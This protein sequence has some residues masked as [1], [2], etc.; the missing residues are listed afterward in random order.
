MGEHQYSGRTSYSQTGEDLLMAFIFEA[1]L[2]ERPSYLDI[3]AYHPI[4]LNNTYYFYLQ[5][6]SGINI[7]PNPAAS[8]AF[9]RL[10]SRDRNLNIGI[11]ASRGS[12]VYHEF[13][14][15]TLNTFSADEAQAYQLLG[16]RLVRSINVEVDTVEN[17]LKASGFDGYP[18][19]LNI[20]VE[21]MELPILQSMKLEKSGPVVICIET[22]EYAPKLGQ[23]KKRNG[24]VAFLEDCGYQVFADTHLNTILVRRAALTR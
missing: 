19:L 24:L 18:Q 5:G 15:P 16:H 13:D 12:M 21:G 20:D 10:R 11:G 3:G 7:E 23:G 22:I 2:I 9:S 6:A 17:V 4:E 14:A 8:E 1:L